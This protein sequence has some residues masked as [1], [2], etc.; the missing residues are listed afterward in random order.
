MICFFEKYGLL[1]KQQYGFRK[2][3][4]CVHATIEIKDFLRNTVEKKCYGLAFYVDFKKAFDTV[5]HAILLDKLD[6]LG[7][8]GK[9]RLLLKDYLSKRYQYVETNGKQSK[10]LEIKCGVPQGS[11]L[12]PLL[13]LLYINDFPDFLRTSEV[14]LFADDT[15]ILNSSKNS[16]FAEQFCDDL[17]HIDDWC[18]NNKLT[19]H[20]SKCKLQQFGKKHI[21]LKEIKLGGEKLDYTTNFKYL[22]VLLD[23]E[24]NF[25]DQMESVYTKLRKFNGIMYRARTCFSKYHLL[26]FYSAYIISIMSFLRTHSIRVWRKK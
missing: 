15:T 6:R 9:F 8:R 18:A 5:D 3:R 25:S 12:G 22:G 14:A 2:K 26:R 13:F 23:C 24:L 11:I 17:K 19:V 20:P 21:E 4:S 16:N 1:A 7:F 10:M